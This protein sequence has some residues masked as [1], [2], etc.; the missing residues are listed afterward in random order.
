MMEQAVLITIKTKEAL[1]LLKTKVS[2]TAIF[3]THTIN[4]IFRWQRCYNYHRARRKKRISFFNLTSSTKYLKIKNKLCCLKRSLCLRTKSRL[5][6]PPHFQI[7]FKKLNV[8]SN[9]VL[10]HTM[11]LF[12]SLSSFLLQIFLRIREVPE[13]CRLPSFFYECSSL[14]VTLQFMI[15]SVVPLQLWMMT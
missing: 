4:V 13:Q 5:C 11:I 9:T 12:S 3:F 8:R 15:L 14:S 6:F 1:L 10:C 2:P 7:S